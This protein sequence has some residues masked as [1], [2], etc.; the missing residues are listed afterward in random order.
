[1]PIAV[2]PWPQS[3][4]DAGAVTSVRA[5][6][7]AGY[8][9][10]GMVEG[11]PSPSRARPS[12][13]TPR[14]RARPSTRF[15][16]TSLAGARSSVRR[17]SI[18]GKMEELLEVSVG[19]GRPRTRRAAPL[20]PVATMGGLDGLVAPRQLL[21]YFV[22]VRAREPWRACRPLMGSCG[23]RASALPAVLVPAPALRRAPVRL[24]AASHHAAKPRHGRPPP[25]RRAARA[26]SI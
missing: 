9:R 13:T 4:R 5:G 16:F 12:R 22:V 24:P 20:A 1:M 14:R 17:L 26:A 19:S 25:S 21:S 3:S 18:A 7:H 6:R 8:S 11:G 2:L 23:S 15:H 10:S